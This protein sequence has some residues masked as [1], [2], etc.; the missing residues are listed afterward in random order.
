MEHVEFFWSQIN[1]LPPQ[2]H[3]SALEIYG[4]VWQFDPRGAFVRL[5]PSAGSADASKEL[6]DRK[7]FDDV[8]I[9]SG[10]EGGNLVAFG[11]SDGEHDD[12][13]GKQSAHPATNFDSVH[14]RKIHV[15]QHDVGMIRQQALHGF[16]TCLCFE[17]FVTSCG[18]S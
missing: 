15:E 7:R 2:L 17:Y 4:H 8:I 6:S 18:K 10:V 9:G 14:V 11:I 12:G 3:P 16:L 1:T 5:K 13:S